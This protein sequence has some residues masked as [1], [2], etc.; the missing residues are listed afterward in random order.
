MNQP[1]AWH[2]WGA[3]AFALAQAQDKPI[4]LDGGCVVPLVPRDGPRVV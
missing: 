4:L 2:E 3:E 1:T